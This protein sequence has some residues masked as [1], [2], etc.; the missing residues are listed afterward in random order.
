[1]YPMTGIT[2]MVFEILAALTLGFV[3]GRIWQ[4][5]QPIYLGSHHVAT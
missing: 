5:T 1:M 4:F 2:V 3:I